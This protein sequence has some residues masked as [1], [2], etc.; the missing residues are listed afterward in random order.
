[1]SNPVNK[2]LFIIHIFQNFYYVS[3]LPK[4]VA[5]R[6]K[7][8]RQLQEK[9]LVLKWFEPISAEDAKGAGVRVF[10]AYKM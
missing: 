10:E 9:K 7:E 6:N 2:V 4:L 1:M 8:R 3:K 5:A